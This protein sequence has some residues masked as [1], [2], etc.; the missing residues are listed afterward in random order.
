MAFLSRLFGSGSRPPPPPD[1]Y[2]VAQAQTEQNRQAALYNAGLN[3]FNT[4]TPFGSQ[5]Y[6][7]SGVDPVTGAPIYRQDIKL[8]PQSEEA[9]RQ[10]LGQSLRLGGAAGGRIDQIEGMDPFS[11]SGLPGLSQDF[12]ALRKE[13]AD[14]LYKRNTAYLDPQFQQS[15]QA[16]RSRLA[17]QGIVEGSEAYNNAMADFNRAKEFSYGQAREGAIAG[18]GAEAERQYGM[19][20]GRRNQ[21]LSEYMLGRQQPFAELEAI[22][23]SMDEINFPQFQGPAQVA[24]APADIAGAMQNQ[25]QGQLDAYNARQQRRNALVSGLFGLGAAAIGRGGG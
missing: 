1:P 12:D 5:E 20:S 21:A 18:G 13:Q 25:Y 19:E 14:A 4:Y 22:R 23:G 24:T 6:S 9:Y 16:L 8:D 15:E 2:A 3:R 17:N 11:L 10:R 7:T